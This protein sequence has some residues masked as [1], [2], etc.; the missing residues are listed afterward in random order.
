M[1]ACKFDCNGLA[2]VLI[3]AAIGAGAHLI[4]LSKI[5]GAQ[6]SNFTAFDL[7]APIPVAFLGLWSGL[8]AIL[9]AK[10]VA[11][12]TLGSPL[13]FMTI[14]RLLPPL[15]AGAFFYAYKQ[16][17][18]MLGA[19]SQIAIPLLAIA[20]FIFH[21]AIF[22]TPAMLYSAYWLIPIAVAFL[23]SFT[24]LRSLGATFCQHAI[25]SITFLYTIP[26]LQNPQVWLALIPIVALERGFFALGITVSYKAFV[27]A[28]NKLG[29]F[30]KN[31]AQNQNLN[32]L[33]NKKGN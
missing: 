14:L 8:A 21:P 5:I 13:D 10:F 29:A 1:K 32:I 6:D 20:L 11:V 17:K 23:P 22:G 4:Q 28:L 33:A 12:L 9:I 16:K 26:A 25:G 2:F 31:P 19:I 30:V 7:M 27:L 24:Y 3:F 18:G 15:A